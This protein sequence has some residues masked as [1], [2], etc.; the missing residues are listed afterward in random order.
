MK[1]AILES[2]RAFYVTFPLIAT[3]HLTAPW[4]RSSFK[5]VILFRLRA[6]QTTRTMQNDAHQ[7]SFSALFRIITL[8]FSADTVRSELR[9]CAVAVNPSLLSY[10]KS[11]LAKP[12][13]LR[14][15]PVEP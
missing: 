15:G 10:E 3:E 4:H 14:P 5:I 13:I 1:T 9:I 7:P 8:R 6:L 11:S 2:G 12:A